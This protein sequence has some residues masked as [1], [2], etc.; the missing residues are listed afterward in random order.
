[1]QPDA[2]GALHSAIYC[3]QVYHRRETPRVHVLNYRVFYLLLDLDES[4]RL[5]EV[6]SLFAWNRRGLLAFHERD[7]GDGSG[8]LRRW[9]TQTLDT[10]GFAPQSWRFR[11]LCMPRVVGHVFNPITVIYCHRTDGTLGAIVYEV[12]NTFGERV[13]YVAPVAE[14]V[15]VIR[16]RCEKAMFVS[17]FFD[18]RGHYDFELTPPGQ[19]LRLTINYCVDA[20]L[21]LRAAFCGQRLPWTAAALRRVAVG[22]PLATLKVVGGIHFEALRLWLKGVPLIRHI[23]RTSPP[24]IIGTEQ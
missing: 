8:Y 7:H 19:S 22:Y 16:Q 15:E 20:E 14:S 1:M 23:V 6:S 4:E 10:S 12:N 9:L 2:D 24:V 11:L 5:A 17:P 18:L 13:A 21:R 3:G